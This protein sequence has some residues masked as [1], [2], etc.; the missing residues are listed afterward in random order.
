[1]YEAKTK[2][3][4]ILKKKMCLD[5]SEVVN[6]NTLEKYFIFYGNLYACSKRLHKRCPFYYRWQVVANFL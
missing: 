4:S 2:T 5:R 1:M 3:L 6:R